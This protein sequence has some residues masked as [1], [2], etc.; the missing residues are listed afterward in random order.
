[1]FRTAA[2]GDGRGIHVISND[3]GS[4]AFAETADLEALRAGRL[5]SHHSRYDDFLSAGFIERAGRGGQGLE[6]AALRTRKA[7]ML[8]GPSL[9]IFVVTLRCDHSCVYCQVSRANLTA[10]GFDMSPEHADAGVDRAF[11][12]SS[13]NITI[14]FQGGEPAL[15]FDLIERIVKVVE[16]RNQTENRQINFSLVSTLHH[17]S[18]EHLAFC[19][20]HNIHIST[21][22]DGGAALHNQ[23]RPLPTK[24]S[25][26]RT[27][28]GLDRARKVLGTAGVVAMPTITKAALTD[29]KALVDTFID[30]GFHSIFLRPLSPHGFAG[31]TRKAVGYLMPE[32]VSFYEQALEYL[33]AL[34][35]SGVEMVEAYTAV[36]L[37]HILTP[38]GSNY[39]D[40][41]S[42]AAAGLG[43]L[44]Y[45]YDGTVYPADEARM[46]AQAGDGRFALGK[47]TEPLPKL[48]SS[49]VMEWLSEGAFAEELPG[50]RDCAFVPYCGAD[51]VYH[52]YAHGDPVGDRVTSEFC[53]RHLGLFDILFRKIAQGDRE[54]MRTFEAWAFGRPRREIMD[55]GLA[56]A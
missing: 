50:C 17:L 28:L 8:H 19:R 21:S 9:H 1:M 56:I 7:F 41:R 32:F 34:N 20:D 35:A 51:P 6:A 39:M 27:V 5:E 45:N 22:V 12:S 49:P 38:F 3:L 18:D 29:P 40:L 24:D 14:E 42:P 37:R 30:L 2:L 53:Q 55:T 13:P 23:Q 48:L 10:P 4:F 15:R 44:V 36:L 25:W 46:A 43:V 11:E 33:L 54:T 47:V 26:Q 52:A 16:G 31:K